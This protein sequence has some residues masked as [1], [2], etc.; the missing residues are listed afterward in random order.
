MM[1]HSECKSGRNLECSSA[2]Y[3]TDKKKLDW[4]DLLVIQAHFL[5]YLSYLPSSYLIKAI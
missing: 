3:H 5:F 2:N 1:I 4:L